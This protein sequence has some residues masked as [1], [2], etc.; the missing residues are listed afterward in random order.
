MPK[1]TVRLRA[2]V[3]LED[4]Q[5]QLKT[6]MNGLC[7]SCR[8]PKGRNPHR[9]E[10]SKGFREAAGPDGGVGLGEMRGKG[11]LNSTDCRGL[12]KWQTSEGPLS[13]EQKAGGRKSR[14]P[15][16]LS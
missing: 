9:L 11:A 2:H 14:G 16:T 10:W 4:I 15:G 8:V 1:V 6:R 12:N 7:V 5:C 13:L 3:D